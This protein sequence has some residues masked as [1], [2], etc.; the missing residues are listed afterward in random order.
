MKSETMNELL[1]KKP[2]LYKRKGEKFPING[3]LYEV[4]LN[5]MNDVYFLK[6]DD[7][8]YIFFSHVE[9]ILKDDDIEEKYLDLQDQFNR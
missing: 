5:H 6:K 9:L 4:R 3:E 2:W 1:I 7:L 8:N